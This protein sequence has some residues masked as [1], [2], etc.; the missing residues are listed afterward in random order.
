MRAA[1]RAMIDAIQDGFLVCPQPR[2]WNAFYQYSQRILNN[3]EPSIQFPK[4]AILTGWAG[5]NDFEKNCIFLL[6]L[7]ILEARQ[8]L[9]LALKF[10]NRLTAQD[11]LISYGPLEPEEKTFFDLVVE[12]ARISQRLVDLF[13]ESGITEIPSDSQGF[14]QDR[15]RRTFDEW[16]RL[17]RG[18]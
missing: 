2:K 18:I 14:K 12:D 1:H 6:Q 5:T 7:H 9:T 11:W 13:R 4:P 16:L 10:L 8:C 17:N 3:G 15:L